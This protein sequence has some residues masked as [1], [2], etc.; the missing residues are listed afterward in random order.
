MPR[1]D[2]LS[3]EKQRQLIR[4]QKPWRQSSGPTTQHGKK[5]SSQ[6]SRKRHRRH[7]ALA[8]DRIKQKLLSGDRVKYIGGFTPTMQACGDSLEV[9][10][11]CSL[12]TGAICCLQ[13]RFAIACR[14]AGGKLILFQGQEDL[15]RIN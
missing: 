10:G 9:A 1:W 6:N 2:L 4:E 15:E 7:L 14:T 12:G 3:R 8:R 11:F 13:Q 5:M